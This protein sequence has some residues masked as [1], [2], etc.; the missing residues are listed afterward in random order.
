MSSP[1][2]SSAQWV[3]RPERGSTALMRVMA[4]ASLALGRR[5]SRVVLRAVAAYFL[6][7]S[8]AA[9]RSARAFLARSLVRAKTLARQYRILLSFGATVHDRI[10]FLADRFELFDIDV[11]GA[12]LFDE[13]G[14]LLMGAHIGSFE[15]MRACARHMGKRRVAMAMYEENARKVNAALDAIAPHARQDIIALGNAGSMIELAARLEEGQLVGVLADR[16]LSDEPTLRLPFLRHAAP[17]PTGPMRMAAALRRRV[18]FM[19]GLYRDGNRY[20]VRFEPLADFS[21]IEGLSRAEREMRVQDAVA[22]YAQRVERLAREAPFNWFNFHD[23]WGAA[24]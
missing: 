17:F 16:T 8:R 6:A 1:S 23:F 3:T 5:S 9:R 11:H 22:A 24:P 21:G 19:V 15:V 4:W 14:A 12:E 18:I 20:E 13:G 2:S 10:Y 7:T